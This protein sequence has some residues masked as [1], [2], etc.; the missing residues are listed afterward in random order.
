[1]LGAGQFQ[2]W[3][4]WANYHQGLDVYMVPLPEN[5]RIGQYPGLHLLLFGVSLIVMLIRWDSGFAR[6]RNWDIPI[7]G[8]VGN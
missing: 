7:D 5:R 8:P 3:K 2:V 1:M 4:Q 6:M